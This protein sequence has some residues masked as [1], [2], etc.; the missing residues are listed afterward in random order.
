MG[1]LM[2]C[3]LPRIIYGI[4]ITV[5]LI[6]NFRDTFA[7][8]STPI[9]SPENILKSGADHC[10]DAS[11]VLKPARFS[12]K[13]FEKNMMVFE[14]GQDPATR[15]EGLRA[16]FEENLP[17]MILN[18]SVTGFRAEIYLHDQQVAFVWVHAPIVNQGGMGPECHMIEGLMA[19]AGSAYGKES[20]L[21]HWIQ[22]ALDESWFRAASNSDPMIQKRFGALNAAV[23]GI[24]PDFVNLYLVW[25]YDKGG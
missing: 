19:I 9:A 7:F 11:L 5:G 15:I 24:A 21:V 22:G 20:D 10:P 18:D 8:D 17:R 25:I 4:L 16:V 6:L 2:K 12:K 13:D 14:Q 3:F 23:W 1:M